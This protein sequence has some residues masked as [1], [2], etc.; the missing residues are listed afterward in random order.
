MAGQVFLLRRVAWVKDAIAKLDRAAGTGHPRGTLRGVALA[1]L[2]A[3]F[4]RAEAAVAELEWVL[5]QRDTFPP[6]LRRSRPHGAWGALSRPSSAETKPGLALAQSGYPLTGPRAPPVHHGLN[7]DGPGRL[8]LPPAAARRGSA[9]DPR[10]AGL[11][12][13]RPRLRSDRCR[14]RGRRCRHHGG[15][16]SARPS[17]ALRRHSS[18]P[19]THVILTHAHW[20]HIGGLAAL[21][22]PGY[23]RDCPGAIR[24]RATNRERHGRAVPLLLRW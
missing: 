3:R 23:A 9:P 21:T 13:R 2:P 1:E 11:R 20:D 17:L 4:G 7:R 14:H 24:E 5:E 15:Q 18:Q 8:S 12:L 10:R 22:A 19:I 16:R 6:G